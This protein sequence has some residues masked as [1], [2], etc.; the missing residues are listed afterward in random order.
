MAESFTKGSDMYSKHNM[1]DGDGMAH[2]RK[3]QHEHF[4]DFTAHLKKIPGYMD[5][6]KA[7]PPDGAPHNPELYNDYAQEPF[8]GIAGENMP[9]S[10]YGGEN[11]S[12][13]SGDHMSSNLPGGSPC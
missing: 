6:D 11:E 2:H 10:A 9:M 12:D 1:H 3:A 4:G 8:H 5:T 13:S 7:G